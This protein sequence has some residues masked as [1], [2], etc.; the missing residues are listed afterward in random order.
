[1]DVTCGLQMTPACC[2]VQQ[3]P[4]PLL[5]N[6]YPPSIISS[7]CPLQ[8][9]CPD[10]LGLWTFPS[11]SWLWPHSQLGSLIQHDREP[12]LP[13]FPHWV[14]LYNV[15]YTW[16][17]LKHG[18]AHSKS[19]RTREVAQ[20][21]VETLANCGDTS[22]LAQAP[23]RESSRHLAPAMWECGLSIS[24]YFSFLKRNWNTGF[25]EEICPFWKC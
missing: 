1:M 21:I 14:G 15:P 8:P 19:T 12:S 6:H 17:M 22:Q 2:K 24:R 20:I 16:P 13:A 18:V 11:A 4:S 5:R 3:L 7:Y 9:S 23:S 10:L 25:V